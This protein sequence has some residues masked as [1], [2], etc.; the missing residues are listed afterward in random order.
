MVVY[1]REGGA[2][3]EKWATLM[4]QPNLSTK[5]GITLSRKLNRLILIKDYKT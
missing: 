3:E 1:G 2:R 5:F 4:G